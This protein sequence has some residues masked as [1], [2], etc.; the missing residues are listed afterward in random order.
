MLTRIFRDSVCIYALF[1]EEFYLIKHT[2]EFNVEK[3]INANLPYHEEK[4][5]YKLFNFSLFNNI[6]VMV[7]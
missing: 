1:P 4:Y 6:F 3:V 5:R 7:F 2:F